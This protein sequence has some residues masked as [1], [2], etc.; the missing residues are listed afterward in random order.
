MGFDTMS[1][2]EELGF[3]ADPREYGAAVEIL[4]D[5]QISNVEIL[6][7]NPVKIEWL[8]RNGITVVK[9]VPLIPKQW[10]QQMFADRDSYLRT[11]IKKM[12]H[13]ITLPLG[14]DC[15]N[16][17]KNEGGS[18]VLGNM[19]EGKVVVNRNCS[20]VVDGVSS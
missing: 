19:R 2:N 17:K 18:K 16:G 20:T 7:N 5:L 9:R 6:T 1:A 11:K 3:H 13:L 10:G 8:R 12:G 4:H 15:E 14:E